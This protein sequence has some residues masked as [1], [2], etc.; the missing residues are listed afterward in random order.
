MRQSQNETKYRFVSA[1][2]KGLLTIWIH[3]RYCLRTE[4]RSNRSVSRICLKRY[5][6]SLVLL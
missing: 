6:A 4:R 2:S 1:M 3:E 5:S